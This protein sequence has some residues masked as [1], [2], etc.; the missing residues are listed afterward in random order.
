M[1]W[2]SDRIL[3]LGAVVF[4]GVAALFAA[5]VWRRGFREDNRALYRL[6][7]VGFAVHTLAMF[8]RGFS[9]ERC[10]IHNLYEATIFV[11]WIVDW[12]ARHLFTR[13]RLGRVR[14]IHF[15]RWRSCLHSCR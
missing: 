2:P 5:L 14:T 8:R 3:F 4:Y 9:L 6:V 12:G 15:A 7:A 11:L 1:S 10:P 13:G